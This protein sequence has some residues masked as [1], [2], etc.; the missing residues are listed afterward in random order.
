MQMPEKVLDC[1]HA[2]YNICIKTYGRQSSLIKYNYYLLSCI[3]C[4]SPHR[5]SDFQFVPLS[6][7]ICILSI[8][9]GGI[10]GVLFFIFLMHIEQTLFNFGCLL[11]EHFD[12][13]CNTSAGM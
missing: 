9:D 13:I 12:L 4:A 8:D 3:L 10:K 7:G 11:Q 6:A 1:S 5:A 2:L